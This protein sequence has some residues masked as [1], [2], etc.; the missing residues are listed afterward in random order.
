MEVLH[1]GDAVIAIVGLNDEW[2]TEEND[3][4]LTTLAL[5]G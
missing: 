5:P 2:E 4:D 3:L 1:L